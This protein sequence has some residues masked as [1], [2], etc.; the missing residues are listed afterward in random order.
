MANSENAQGMTSAIF[1]AASFDPQPQARS[2][3]KV[4]HHLAIGCGLNKMLV[5]ALMFLFGAGCGGEDADKAR[6]S[7]KPFTISEVPENVMAAAKAALPDVEF[8]DTWKNMDKDGKL[9]SYEIRGRN[10]VGKIRECRV[11]LTGEILEME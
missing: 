7:R 10:K 11:S 3:V 8:T 1:G 6:L 5:M 4:L 9:H 2:H